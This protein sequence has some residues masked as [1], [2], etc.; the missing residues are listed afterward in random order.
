MDERQDNQYRH[1]IEVWK[2]KT[3]ARVSIFAAHLAV[4]GAFSKSALNSIILANSASAGAVLALIGSMWGDG[5]LGVIFPY[6]IK[7]LSI[8]AAGVG[9]AI[10][11]SGLAYV[12]QLFYAYGDLREFDEKNNFRLLQRTGMVFHAIAITF[13]LGAI[14]SF[15]AGA[16]FALEALRSLN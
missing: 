13:G 6:C 10:F 16:W 15:C 12:A 4:I 7:A 8:F 9:L 14:L 1:Q 3:P 11:T 2:V 5:A